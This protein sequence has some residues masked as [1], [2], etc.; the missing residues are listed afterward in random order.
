ML[1]FIYITLLCIVI[2]GV[3]D[4]VMHIRRWDIQQS[5]DLKNN[6]PASYADISFKVR[7]HGFH[8]KGSNGALDAYYRGLTFR[9]ADELYQA[10]EGI[11]ASLRRNQDDLPLV[12]KQQVLKELRG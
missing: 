3:I 5:I 8:L 11:L 2:L 4:L 7:L 1:Y 10:R 9:V 12:V 6:P